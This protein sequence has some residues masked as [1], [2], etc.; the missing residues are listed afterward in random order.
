MT[1]RFGLQK[2]KPTVIHAMQ[3]LSQEST[4]Y[5]IKKSAP[6]K[7]NS[8]TTES[9]LPRIGKTP[10]AKQA[11]RY[12]KSSGSWKGKAVQRSSKLLPKKSQLQ[13]FVKAENFIGSKTKTFWLSLNS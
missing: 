1:Y 5:T 6:K 4:E 8:F 11:K 3:T 2:H 12:K 10:P 13:K 7:V 9:S